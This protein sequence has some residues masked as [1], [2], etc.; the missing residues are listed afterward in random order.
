M[1]L[2]FIDHTDPDLIKEKEA[3][4]EY[5]D[6][7]IHNVKLAYGK[8]FLSNEGLILPD[9]TL[10]D[11]IDIIDASRSYIENHDASKYSQ[12]EFDG[13]RRHFN[14]TPAEKKVDDIDSTETDAQFN[15]A[16]KHHFTY[17]SHHPL[18]WCWCNIT[19]RAAYDH[20]FDWTVESRPHAPIDM[21]IISIIEMMSDWEA[22]S[23][24]NKL[25]SVDFWKNH[26]KD[27]RAA[28]TQKTI[29]YVDRLLKV[30]YPE[31]SNGEASV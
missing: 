7:H 13:Y 22:M 19:Q 20:P 10:S 11:S 2:F 14:P 21:D 16:W 9:Y 1:A 6:N 25:S 5:V 28:M 15:E 23:M 29:D 24:Y 27:E 18:F 31:D 17:N 8:L 12:E 4:M 26:A 30:L 3:Y